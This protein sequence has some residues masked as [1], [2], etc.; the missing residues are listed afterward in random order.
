[1]IPKDTTPPIVIRACE[2]RAERLMWVEVANRLREEGYKP[3]PYASLRHKCNVLRRKDP[4][5]KAMLEQGLSN[6]CMQLTI[7]GGW[8][9]ENVDRSEVHGR[10]RKPRGTE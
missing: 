10:K 3:M 1:M 4:W 8:W 5:V 2:L 7:R 6:K 9:R